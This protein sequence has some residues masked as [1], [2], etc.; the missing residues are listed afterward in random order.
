VKLPPNY[1]I[2]WGGDFENLQ[3]ASLR[4]AIITP[5]VLM[6]IFLLLYTSLK[7]GSAWQR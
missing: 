1:R 3:S 6:I 5:I 2:E 4:L 7:S